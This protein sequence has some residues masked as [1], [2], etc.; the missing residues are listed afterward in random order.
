MRASSLTHSLP[1]PQVW[2]RKDAP[3]EVELTA[4]RTQAALARKAQEKAAA[5]AAAAA[6][7]AAT[8]GGKAGSSS[9]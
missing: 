6:A 2:E 5:I 7:A 3:R 9:K 8:K 1:F 4:L